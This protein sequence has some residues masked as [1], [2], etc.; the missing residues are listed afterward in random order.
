M[1]YLGEKKTK[2]NRPPP[3]LSARILE[4]RSEAPRQGTHR[5]SMLLLRGRCVP[6]P[7]SCMAADFRARAS[8]SD[9]PSM[10]D[11][12]SVLHGR[13]PLPSEKRPFHH[14]QLPIHPSQLSP[15][16]LSPRSPLHGGILSLLF[17]IFIIKL[18]IININR[19]TGGPVAT[20]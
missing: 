20:T 3:L 9:L 15:N 2:G 18:L 1:F 4:P 7:F 17:C 19:A 10:T 16:F 8:P 13:P 12:L 11:F 6:L 14:G 5:H